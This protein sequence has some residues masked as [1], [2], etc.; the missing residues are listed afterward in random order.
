MSLCMNTAITPTDTLDVAIMSS[1]LEE[2]ENIT[3]PY[4]Q[5]G[6]CLS[7]F[8][9]NVAILIALKK[10]KGLKPATTLFIGKYT[11]VQCHNE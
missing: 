7:I 1:N 6:I 9:G 4:V 5:L 11:L 10:A 2:T 3:S 8:L